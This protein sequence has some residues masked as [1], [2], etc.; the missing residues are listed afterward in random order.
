[1]TKVFKQTIKV[2]FAL[3]LLTIVFVGFLL[4][5]GS[6]AWFAKNENVS[7]TGLSAQVQFSP[8]LIIAKDVN[9]IKENDYLAFGIDF[10]GTARSDMIAVTRDE[11]AP[12]TFLKYLTSHYAVDFNTGNVKDGYELQFAPVPTENNQEYFIDYT[13]YIASAFK[14][15]EVESLSATITIPSS[16]DNEHLYFNA[17]SIDFY[18]EEVSL[19]G[20]RGTTSV[21]SDQS[22]DIFSGAGGTVPL[23]TDGY[24][25]V[26]MRCYFDGALQDT[27]SGKAYVNSEQVKAD[28]VVIGVNFVAVE[29]ETEE[30]SN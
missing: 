27:T 20:Y 28:G 8:N 19:E 24:I 2:I 26:I 18:V 23:N 13:I 17:A 6:M 14:P 5:N 16:V 22:V 29:T 30:E 21:A 12:E 9:S 25:K 10:K 15:L 4:S 11:T 7:A 1:M 3:I